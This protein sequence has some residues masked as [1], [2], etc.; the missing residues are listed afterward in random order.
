MSAEKLTFLEHLEELRSR[1]IKCLVSLA[2]SSILV[3]FFKLP[4]L[5]FIIRPV[6]SLV[7]I[8]PQ[9]A[10]IANLKIALFGGLFLSAP[11]FLY[12]TW[13][14]ILYG[15]DNDLKKYLAFLTIGSFFLFFIGSIFGYFI[16]V[17]IG[18]KFLLGFSTDFLIPM[19]TVSKYISFVFLLTFM[20][21]VVFELPLA[22][23]FLTKLNIIT[24]RFL[25][26]KRRYAIVIIFIIGAI[27]TPPDVIT[28]CLLAIPL[29]ILYELSII[30]AKLVRKS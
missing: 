2:I 10:F 7:F 19:I 3:Y 6:G 13:K 22:I 8:S 9:E 29:L 27:F 21:G 20:L 14:F 23:L 5:K 24:P 26:E 18:M 16:V 11:F 28:Q 1:I 25:I 30:L 4:V 15:L 12:Q 17:P